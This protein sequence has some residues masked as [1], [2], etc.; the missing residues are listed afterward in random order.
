MAAICFILGLLG[1][2]IGL[3]VLGLLGLFLGAL[4]F[5]L[6]GAVIGV[7]M[8]KTDT[9]VC[10]RGTDGELYF[11]HHQKR[12]D[13]LRVELSEPLRAIGS[14]GA[15]KPDAPDPPGSAGSPDSAALQECGP[16]RRQNRSLI[17]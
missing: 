13:A 12:P 1:A 2:V 5:G 6:V 16:T 3:L 14:A 10:I 15:V 9:I 11:L 8:T 17:S 7:S 4:L